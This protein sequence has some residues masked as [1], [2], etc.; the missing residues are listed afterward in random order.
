MCAICNWLLLH[1]L[2]L[3][4]S[5]HSVLLRK[6]GL[7]RTMSLF[8]RISGIVDRHQTRRSNGKGYDARRVLHCQSSRGYLGLGLLALKFNVIILKHTRWTSWQ[9]PFHHS[10]DT[11]VC[12][13]YVAANCPHRL[14]TTQS[15]ECSQQ[16]VSSENKPS[17]S[18]QKC[19]NFSLSCQ[20]MNFIRWLVLFPVSFLIGG[21]IWILSQ[22]YLPV[23][24]CFQ[25]LR[26]N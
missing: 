26:S 3:C 23:I 10:L 11:C 21:L 24:G 22:N 20:N 25:L 13:I 18:F 5:C 15:F 17:Y 8:S 12:E 7:C 1:L 9:S 2:Y 14:F 4:P 6:G 19:N 16:T